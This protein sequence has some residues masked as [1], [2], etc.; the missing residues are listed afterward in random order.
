MTNIIHLPQR[1]DDDADYNRAIARLMA[2]ETRDRAAA[3]MAVQRARRAKHADLRDG[4]RAPWWLP[5]VIGAG[6]AIWVVIGVLAARWGGEAVMG[7]GIW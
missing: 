4:Y 1:P 2:D 6:T 3:E 5:V 7:W